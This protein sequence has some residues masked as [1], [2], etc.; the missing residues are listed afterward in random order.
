MEK[1]HNNLLA[2]YEKIFNEVYYADT[3]VEMLRQACQDKEFSGQY[4][5][6]S[7]EIALKLSEERNHYINMLDLLSERIT[8]IKTLNLLLEQAIML[9][10]YT[11]NS[12]R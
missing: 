8:N 4:Y 7:K 1:S 2:V 3:I 5:G 10:Q 6:I 9:Q 11:H 12:C